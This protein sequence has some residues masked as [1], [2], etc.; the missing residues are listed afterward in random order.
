[1]KCTF[2]NKNK[3]ITLIV[4]VVTIIILLVLSGVA[5]NSITSEEGLLKKAKQAKNITEEEQKQEDT[6]LS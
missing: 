1:M 2:G 6:K 4:L 5:I 3:G